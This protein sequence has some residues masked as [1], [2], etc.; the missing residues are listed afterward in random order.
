VFSK[1]QGFFALLTKISKDNYIK[2]V[3]FDLKRAESI[4]F[5]KTTSL[6]NKLQSRVLFEVNFFAQKLDKNVFC[7]FWTR[8][9][10]RLLQN[11]VSIA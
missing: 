6:Q 9:V 5:K 2:L 10:S 4:I 3:F 7:S 11:I 8:P 1:C